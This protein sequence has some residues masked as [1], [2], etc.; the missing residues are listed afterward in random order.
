MIPPF[1]QP[2]YSIGV[3]MLFSALPLPMAAAGEGAGSES[4]MVD[5][6]H[7]A[8]SRRVVRVAER[9]N[10]Y[11]RNTFQGPENHESPL[12]Q[13]FY[14]DR[15]TRYDVE[16]SHIRISPRAGYSRKFGPRYNLDFSVRLRLGDISEHL[17]F[18]AS[19][20]GPE[21]DTLDGVF[22]RVSRRE[23]GREA[24]DGPTAGLIY[25]FTDGVR[26][27][28]SLSG[29]LRMTPAPEPRVRLRGSL[30]KEFDNW[31]AEVAQNVFWDARDGFGEK[32][33]FQLAYRF[34][35]QHRF[36]IATSAEWSEVSQGVD[37]DLF[38]G[39]FAH[40]TPRQSLALRVGARGHTEPD[41][42]T[43]QYLVRLTYRQRFLRDWLFLEVEPG[44]DFFRE[45]RYQTAPL[46]EV[47]F[48]VL[49]GSF[50]RL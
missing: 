40:F 37:W 13:H 5:R 14:G 42:V 31:Q 49:F 23:T 26:R 30:R 12:V 18:F 27:S 28:V 38:A 17:T 34:N 29:G 19:G 20:D 48:D 44:L 47:K 1:L 16:G 3:L 41:W 22:G 4:A 9:I 32:T 24:E 10:A 50:E 45:D 35:E 21:R 7:G 25:F 15:M 11:L 43:D 39:H 6:Q 36:R 46:V 2:A 8:V 33:Q